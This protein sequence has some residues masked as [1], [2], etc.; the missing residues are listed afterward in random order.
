MAEPD[1]GQQARV[2]LGS[3]DGSRL[4]VL[5]RGFKPLVYL[6]FYMSISVDQKAVI[7]KDFQRAEGDTGSP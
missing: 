3:T 6:E 4:A 2:R 1:A 7:V 5:D